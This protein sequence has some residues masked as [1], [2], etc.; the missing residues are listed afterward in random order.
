MNRAFLLEAKFPKAARTESGVLP[1][2]VNKTPN[3][4]ARVKVVD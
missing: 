2:D 3:A 4:A 1:R